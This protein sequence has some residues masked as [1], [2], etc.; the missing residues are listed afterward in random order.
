MNKLDLFS[1]ILK[2]ENKNSLKN[3]KKSFSTYLT[4]LNAR[5][6]ETSSTKILVLFFIFFFKFIENTIYYFIFN[7]YNIFTRNLLMINVFGIYLIFDLF[8][9]LFLFFECVDTLHRRDNL[10]LSRNL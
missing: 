5:E 2:E 1:L 10:D 8:F 4:D 9:F 7:I 6:K 3:E